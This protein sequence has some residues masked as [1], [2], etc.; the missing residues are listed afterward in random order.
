MS[1][2]IEHQTCYRL[3]GQPIRFDVSCNINFYNHCWYKNNIKIDYEEGYY[4]EYHCI[5]ENAYGSYICTYHDANSIFYCE[6]FKLMP[7]PHALHPVHITPYCQSRSHSLQIEPHSSVAKHYPYPIAFRETPQTIPSLWTTNDTV[8][9]PQHK[10]QQ[11]SD[12]IEPHISVQQES[13]CMPIP[14]YCVRE[15]SA[16]ES[17]QHSHM[18]TL[19]SLYIEPHPLS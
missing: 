10:Q 8:A 3:V 7:P 16:S 18:S 14:A 9:F 17:L 15:S 12:R 11:H 5:Q 6:E 4:L 19:H 13:M 1:F 2:V